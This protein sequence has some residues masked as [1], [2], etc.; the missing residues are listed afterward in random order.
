MAKA[1]RKAEEKMSDEELKRLQDTSV[2][3]VP[4]QK[5]EDDDD[6]KDK[7]DKGEDDDEDEDDDDEDDDDTKKAKKSLSVEQKLRK[8]VTHLATLIRGTDPALR[9]EALFAKS[10]KGTHLSDD[11][12]AELNALVT[13]RPVGEPLAERAAPQLSKSLKKAVSESEAV[14]ELAKS[15]A[16]THVALCNEFDSLKSGVDEI[17]CGMAKA[18]GAVAEAVASLHEGQAN[19]AEALDKSL[20]QP[21]YQP[22]SQG[23]SYH[24]RPLSGAKSEGISIQKSEKALREMVNAAPDAGSR[25][26]FAKAL[27]QA[28]AFKTVSPQVEQMVKAHLGAQ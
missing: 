19:I 7:F 27:F 24:H 10:I 11:E 9:K 3:D 4:C 20:S 21:A 12:A 25:D 26:T 2:K 5:A 18:L 28:Q 15:V 13:G 16:G 6:D 17:H 22:R 23:V 14:M 8:A 1:V